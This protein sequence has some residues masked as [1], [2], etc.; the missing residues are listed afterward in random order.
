LEKTFLQKS[1]EKVEMLKL[2]TDNLAL[3]FANELVW[4]GEDGFDLGNQK[5]VLVIKTDE[6]VIPIANMLSKE[7]IEG[8]QPNFEKTDK[9][10]KLLEQLPTETRTTL[11]EFNE[12]TENDE[13]FKEIANEIDDMEDK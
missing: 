8:M 13:L 11:D 1:Y 2:S 5:C 12:N 4:D 6:Q 10:W 7:A 3:M 9:L